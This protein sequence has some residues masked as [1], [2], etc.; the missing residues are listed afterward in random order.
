MEPTP[1]DISVYRTPNPTTLKY[2]LS[3]EDLIPGSA[4][5][6]HLPRPV[7]AA[8]G[9]YAALPESLQLF[10][11]TVVE[12]AGT[13]VYLA[14]SPEARDVT[15][16]YFEDCAVATPSQAARDDRTARRLWE[17][18]VEAAGLAPEAVDGGDGAE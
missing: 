15:G 5:F 8:V 16:E 12:G 4:F 1:V 7:R 10:T 3:R 14:A 9:V 13:S 6:R 11:D 18:S 17:W 2:I